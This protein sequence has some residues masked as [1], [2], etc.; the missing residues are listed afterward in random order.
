[1][2]HEIKKDTTEFKNAAKECRAARDADPDGFHETW[3]TNHNG[4]NAFG[5]CVSSKV[6]HQD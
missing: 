3:G 2:K 5:K 4:R 6:K 1:V